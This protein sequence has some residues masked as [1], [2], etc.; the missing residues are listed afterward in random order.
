LS[1][2]DAEVEISA[3][4]FKPAQTRN[5]FIE[6]EPLPVHK[7]TISTMS[8]LLGGFTESTIMVQ[9]SPISPLDASDGTLVIGLPE[10]KHTFLI[11]SFGHSSMKVEKEITS[12]TDFTVNLE[13]AQIG[14]IDGRRSYF[15]MKPVPIRG[16]L[17]PALDATGLPWFYWSLSSGKVTANQLSRFPYLIW[18]AGGTL[19]T[20]EISTLGQYLDGGGKLVLTSSFFGA[21]YF[22]ETETT[23]FLASYFH[24]TGQEDGGMTVKWSKQGNFRSLALTTLWGFA[25]SSRL[26][27]VDSKAKPFLSYAGNEATSYAGLKVSTPKTQ[28]IILG[29]TFPDISSIDDSKWLMKMCIDSFEDT[30]SWQSEVT[31]KNGKPLSGSVKVSGDTVPFSDGQLFVPHIPASGTQVLVSSFGSST[32][33]LQITPSYLPQQVTLEPAK[34]GQLKI[35]LNTDAWLLFEDVPVQPKKVQAQSALNLPEGS[36]QM[37]IAARNF[38]PRTLMV[39]VPGNLDV[40]LDKKDSKIL[41]NSSNQKLTQAIGALKLPFEVKEDATAGDIISSQAFVCSASTLP[42]AKT[43]QMI[44]NIKLAASCGANAVVM[45]QGLAFSYGDQIQIDTSSTPVFSVSGQGI[46]SGLLISTSLKDSG[47]QVLGVPVITGGETIASFIGVGGAIVKL[48]NVIVSAFPFEMIDLDV[49]AAETLRRMLGSM[50]IKGSLPQGKIIPGTNPSKTSDV[51]ITGIAVPMTSSYLRIDGAESLINLDPEGFFTYQA[52]LS[53]G[54]HKIEIYSKSESQVSISQPY[55]LV[56]DMTAPKIKIWSPRG[57][58]ISTPDVELIATI[59]GAA[60]VSI[61]GAAAKVEGKLFKTKI[62][63]GSGLIFIEA[64]DEAGN[65]SE[66]TAT[67]TFKPSFSADSKNSGFW[68]EINQISASGICEQNDVFSPEKIMTRLETAQWVFNMLELEPVAGKSGYSDVSESSKYAGIINALV[69]NGI[70]SGK[71]KFEGDQACM[72]EFLVAILANS[73]KTKKA[74]STAP[75]SDVLP[76]SPYFRIIAKAVGI[77]I[78]NPSDGRIFSNGKFGLSQK[79]KRSQAAALFFNTLSAMAKG[80]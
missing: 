23:P 41:I 58:V 9:D 4:G 65:R 76:S 75:F 73:V 17:K 36:Y 61:D 54:M 70:I 2:D 69:K 26:A 45:G 72:R 55:N 60:T 10:G 79:V 64:T 28:G 18:N 59:E 30:I 48:D 5:D 33:S 42:N 21:S 8:P 35:N 46:L 52:N 62:S 24:C 71:G 32:T 29:F 34:T 37:T 50:G 78:I 44:D 1:A 51:T 53:E 25:S 43:T 6:L 39:K 22:G 63:A 68:Y 19:D 7:V 20:K 40:Q 16:K 67:Y 66:M 11:T 14:F 49:V 13:P 77:G 74:W 47:Y 38:R 12:D 80:E 3:F 27:P 57:G 15:G 56:V 31:D